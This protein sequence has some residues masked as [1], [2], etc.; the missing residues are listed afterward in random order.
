MT[1]DE[2]KFTYMVAG[3]PEE[4]LSIFEQQQQKI[5]EL[6]GD[7]RIKSRHYETLKEGAH[8]LQVERLVNKSSFLDVYKGY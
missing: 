6:E 2:I 1:L 4:L 3:G 8:E 5:A 7:L